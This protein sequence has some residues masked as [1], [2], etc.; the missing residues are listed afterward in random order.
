MFRLKIIPDDTSIPFVKL[1]KLG[2]VF[3]IILVLLSIGSFLYQGLNLGIDF[4]GGILIEA[5]SKQGN[6]DVENLRSVLGGESYGE[7]A[8]QL[9]GAKDEVLIRI[10]KQDGDEKAQAKVVQQI[11]ALISDNYKV[12]RTE[13]VG[14]TIGAELTQKGIIAV[15]SALAAI[16]IYIWFRFEWQYSIA[17]IIALSHDVLTTIGFFALTSF[18]FNLTTIAAILTISGYSINDTVVVF[19]RIRENFRRYKS[20]E[21]IDI[22]NKSLNE[23]LSRT[24]MTSVTT[25]L[26]LIAIIIFGGPVLRDFSTAMLWGVLIGTYSSIFIAA[27]LLTFVTISRSGDDN[28]DVAKAELE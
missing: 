9:F 16:M 25:A 4:K 14:P 15:I 12:R 19:D 1:F 2:F 5:K 6:A 3:S 23:T 17:A 26:A 24:V 10:Q 8:I 20:W 28:S 13:F 27:G 11:N 22:I 21:Q 18:E 7:V